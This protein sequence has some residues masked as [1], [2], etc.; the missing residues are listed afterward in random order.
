MN[1]VC[2]EKYSKVEASLDFLQAGRV[3]EIN[4][5]RG[6]IIE[7]TSGKREKPNG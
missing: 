2:W 4:S 3:E 6:E 1:D 5:S 7:G